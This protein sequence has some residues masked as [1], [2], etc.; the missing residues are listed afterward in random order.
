MVKSFLFSAA[1]MSAAVV[2]HPPAIEV[3]S[4][5]TS[6]AAEATLKVSVKD[7]DGADDISSI[8]ILIHHGIATANACYIPNNVA[9]STLALRNNADTA[10]GSDL[11]VGAAARDSNSQCEIDGS[12]SSVV[13]DSET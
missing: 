4:P 11:Q 3:F 8:R 9:A 1:V 6:A 10:W 12:Q 13:Q 2:G 5:L 7:P